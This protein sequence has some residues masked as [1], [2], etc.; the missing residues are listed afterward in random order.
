[1]RFPFVST[2]LI[3]SSRLGTAWVHNWFQPI[4]LYVAFSRAKLP[5]F[6]PG[7]YGVIIIDY[8]L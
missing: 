4:P 3:T 1:M 8:S 2:S 6:G 5:P 7:H